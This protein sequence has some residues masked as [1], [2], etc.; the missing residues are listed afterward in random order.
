MKEKPKVSVI[1]PCYDVE[2]YLNRCLNSLVNQTLKDIEIILVDDGSPDRVPEKCDEWAKKDSR[3]KV[4]HKKNAGLGYA[5]NT[6]LDVAIGEYVAF[7]DSDD[8][9]ELNMYEKLYKVAK[10]HDSDVV[11]CGFKKEFKHNYFMN[12]QECNDYTEFTNE[13]VKNLIPDFITSEPY[14]K[15]EYKYEMSVWHSIY[16][17][18]IIQEHH[19]RFISEREYASE[20]IPFQ[21]D[22]LSFAYRVSFIPDMLYI[23]CF[24]EESLTKAFPLE[25]YYKIRNLFYLIQEKSKS[26]DTKGLRAKRLFIGYVRSYLRKWV[27]CREKSEAKKVICEIMN[28]EVWIEIRKIYHPSFLPFHQRLLLKAIY[29]RNV[30]MYY[31]LTKCMDYKMV[32][33]IKKMFNK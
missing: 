21:I 25:R 27:R 29:Y 8:Y 22:F 20:D 13:T 30:D 24:N 15:S 3:I 32:P 14:R 2:R 12:V 31:L 11:Y 17:R 23:Y 26:Y 7:V 4:I 1:V 28:D 6:G 10:N 19:L 9:V 33:K 16:K 18:L 5:R